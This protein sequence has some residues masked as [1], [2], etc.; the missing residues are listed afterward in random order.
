M[1]NVE[2]E[3]AEPANGRPVGCGADRRAQLDHFGDGFLGNA[4]RIEQSIEY[5]RRHL[6]QPLQV[7]RLAALVNVSPSHFFA[8]FKRQT[9]CAP[10]DFFIRLRM[11]Q[12]CELLDVTL[13][14]VK[15]VAAAL[16]YED[17]FYFS[18]TFKAVTH[19]A[20]SEYRMM[21]REFKDAIRS[22]VLPGVISDR[23]GSSGD[24]RTS[25]WSAPSPGRMAIQAKQRAAGAASTPQ[26]LVN[27]VH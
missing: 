3:A 6:D 11:E 16:G 20:P 15:E 19:V 24:L 1:K 23:P 25:R 7:A 12:A 4:E 9:G 18:R 5:M 8:L 10:I 22:A 27:A 13:S 17:P 14:N 21:S 26:W 2:I